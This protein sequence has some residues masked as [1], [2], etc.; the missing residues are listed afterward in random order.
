MRGA[1]GVAAHIAQYAQPKP[2]HMI[3]KGRTHS[4]VILVIACTLNLERFP[5]EG[6]SILSIED[7]SAHT[8]RYMFR[9][10]HL[11]ISLDGH[12]GRVQIGLFY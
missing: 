6:K 1:H 7:R 10:T 3:G 8:E 2:L 12:N 9:I 4:S 11:T 5:I